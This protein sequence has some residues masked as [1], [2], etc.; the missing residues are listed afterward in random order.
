MKFCSNCGHELI[1]EAA[2]CPNCGSVVGKIKTFGDSRSKA[3]AIISFLF[4]LLG[5]ILYLIWRDDRPLRSAS[6]RKG[7]CAVFILILL[8]IALLSIFSVLAAII[9]SV[10]SR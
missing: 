8:I 7:F 2:I 4:P 1:D 3:W 5:I 6:I 9:V 10:P